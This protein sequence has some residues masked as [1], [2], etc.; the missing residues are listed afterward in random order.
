[1]YFDR[2]GVAGVM[3]YPSARL[4]LATNHDPR[5]ADRSKGVWRRMLVIPFRVGIPR[6]RQDP[7]LVEKLKAELSGIFNW[8][9]TGLRALRHSGQFIVPAIS[10]QMWDDLR[11]QSNYTNQFLVDTCECGS[12]NE[13]L[14][15]TAL[16]SQ[17]EDWCRERG[18]KVLDDTKFGKELRRIFAGIERRRDGTGDRSWRYHGLRRLGSS[19]ANAASLSS[20]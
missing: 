6:E 1:M 18:F 13:S 11:A 7:N 15:C 3:V 16:Y 12:L 2:K 4:I 19:T 8:S 14:A 17:Y 10:Q 5:F 9:I 20:S